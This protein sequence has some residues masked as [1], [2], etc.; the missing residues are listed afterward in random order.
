MLE[1]RKWHVL[2]PGV[3]G[4]ACYRR[5]TAQCWRSITVAGRLPT[6]ANKETKSRWIVM[7]V[8]GVHT[9][10]WMP[11]VEQRRSSCRVPSEAEGKQRAAYPWGITLAEGRDPAL[12]VQ[13]KSRGSGD[14]H[15]AS[16]LGCDQDATDDGM[17]A[18][19]RAT[20]EQLPRKLYAKAKQ[21]TAYCCALNG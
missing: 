14:C 16:H 1:E 17:D 9:T 10:A 13:P 4:T 21:E 3:A 6:T 2:T 19:G 20:Q 18:G 7:E 15:V 12:F 5:F 11:E 8:G